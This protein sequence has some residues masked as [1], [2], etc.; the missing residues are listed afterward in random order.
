MAAL[1][2]EFGARE[3]PVGA[4]V[5]AIMVELIA[6]VQALIEAGREQRTIPPGPPARTLAGATLAAI[7]G[8]VIALSGHAE[9]DE[10]VAERVARGIIAII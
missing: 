2:V 9:D 10:E 7:E 8:T 1:R 3:H 6:R 5:R 4:A